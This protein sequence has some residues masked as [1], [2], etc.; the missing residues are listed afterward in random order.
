MNMRFQ[1]DDI[2]PFDNENGKSTIAKVS[3]YRSEESAFADLVVHAQI[4][5]NWESSLSEVKQQ[6]IDEAKSV[7]RQIV[8][9]L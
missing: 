7:L 1:V 9:N 5:L 6:L 2:T 4:P 8:E 3:V